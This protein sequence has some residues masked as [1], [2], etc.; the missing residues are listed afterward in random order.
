[1]HDRRRVSIS[2]VYY[3]QPIDI[4]CSE[5][6]TQHLATIIKNYFLW[7]YLNFKYIIL[8]ICNEAGQLMLVEEMENTS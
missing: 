7:D 1:M 8:S 4:Q 3:D 2:A 5:L 6:Y